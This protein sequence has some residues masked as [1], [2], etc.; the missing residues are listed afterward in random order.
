MDKMAS[1]TF[2]HAQDVSTDSVHLK[3]HKDVTETLKLVL[4]TSSI[5]FSCWSPFPKI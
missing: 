4:A 2:V 1:Q 3:A 5:L